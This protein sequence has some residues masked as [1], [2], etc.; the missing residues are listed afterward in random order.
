MIIFKS[1]PTI[2]SIYYTVD[3]SLVKCYLDIIIIDKVIFNRLCF[4][5]CMPC[6]TVFNV[7]IFYLYFT[8]IRHVISKWFDFSN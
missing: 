1:F 4:W 5:L 7:W 3:T 2:N 6:K 8:A